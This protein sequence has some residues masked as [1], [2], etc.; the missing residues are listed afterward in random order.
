[1]AKIPVSVA[2]AGVVEVTVP[3]ALPEWRQRALAEKVA[4]CRVVATTLREDDAWG[5]VIEGI[6][7]EWDYATHR[8]VPQNRTEVTQKQTLSLSVD[9]GL[10]MS[11]GEL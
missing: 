11:Q 6:S 4:M 3:D 9:H 8:R 5:C 2:F 1:M 7:G 10:R